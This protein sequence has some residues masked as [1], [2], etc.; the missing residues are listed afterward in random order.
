MY[1]LA[2]TYGARGI[3]SLVVAYGGALAVRCAFSV[4]CIA[5][6][7]AVYVVYTHIGTK[8]AF[9]LHLL[10]TVVGCTGTHEANVEQIVRPHKYAR[11]GVT[12]VR[13]QELPLV[14]LAAR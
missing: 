9:A 13:R 6:Y 10:C 7:L 4:C 12:C 3:G 2:A 5:P 14:C 11:S 1:V 8:S